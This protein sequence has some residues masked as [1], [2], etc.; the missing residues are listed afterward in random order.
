MADGS[1]GGRRDQGEGLGRGTCSLVSPILRM[2]ETLEAERWEPKE[3]GGNWGGGGSGSRRLWCPRGGGGHMWGPGLASELNGERESRGQER[4]DNK[5]HSP[6]AGTVGH[7]A[8]W[9]WGCG[10]R[11]RSC[12]APSRG[13]AVSSS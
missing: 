11:N 2:R 3:S 9:G 5:Q 8:G 13:D 10:E 12:L 1:P 4:T 7:G 6:G